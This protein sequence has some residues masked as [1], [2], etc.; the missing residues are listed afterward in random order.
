MILPP[1]RWLILTSQR[2]DVARADA[3]DPT[4]PL[5]KHGDSEMNGVEVIRELGR[6]RGSQVNR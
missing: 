3:T 2:G 6:L 5:A 4:A 1:S